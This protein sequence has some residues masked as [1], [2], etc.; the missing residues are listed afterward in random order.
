MQ[1]HRH[2]DQEIYNQK[3]LQLSKDTNT[4]FIITTDSH[5]SVKEHL[6]YQARHV[7]IARDADTMSESYEGCYIQSD[8]EIHDIMDNQIG[9]EN[10]D[11]GLKNTSYNFV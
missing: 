5:A 4:P 9:K 11:T 10:V 7:Q 3:I 1:S 8:E 2:V 6:K